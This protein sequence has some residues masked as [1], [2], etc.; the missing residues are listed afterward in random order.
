[1]TTTHAIL[2]AMGAYCALAAIAMAHGAASRLIQTAA[3]R[4]AA[5]ITPIII[6]I[7]EMDGALEPSPAPVGVNVYDDGSDPVMTRNGR[8]APLS[9]EAKALI[10][11]LGT[12]H[13][14]LPSGPDG[15][16]AAYMGAAKAPHA[17][18]TLRAASAE[19]DRLRH[20]GILKDARDGA[21]R[22]GHPVDAEADAMM[23]KMGAA[24]PKAGGSEGESPPDAKDAGW[25]SP[26]DSGRPKGPER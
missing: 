26:N 20:A 9:A 24:P 16:S 2:Y 14:T 21:R 19:E 8:I 15:E 18:A 22:R 1:M 13:R 23:A 17:S 3:E 5:R 7:V 4:R 11:A 25:E 10:M 12:A 6:G